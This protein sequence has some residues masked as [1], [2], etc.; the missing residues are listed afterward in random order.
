MTL[1]FKTKKVTTKAKNDIH[2]QND[3]FLQK[4]IK[5]NIQK[6]K[7]A[8]KTIKLST[9]MTNKNASYLDKPLVAF[10]LLGQYTRHRC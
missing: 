3:A 7:R 6:T 9:E 5:S 8:T 1:F 4:T 2:N 10:F